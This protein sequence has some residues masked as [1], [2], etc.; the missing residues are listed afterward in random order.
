MA[1]SGEATV[2]TLGRHCMR[3]TGVFLAKSASGS[4]GC[5]GSGDAD[6]LLPSTWEH[7]HSELGVDP[8]KRVMVNYTMEHENSTYSSNISVAKT[9]NPF[10]ITFRNRD[11]QNRTGTFEIYLWFM[12]STIC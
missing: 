6:I 9:L 2:E 11:S 5:Q 8:C 4:I 7:G 10:T 3:V 1:W 12:H